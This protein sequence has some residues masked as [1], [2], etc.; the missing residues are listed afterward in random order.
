MFKESQNNGNCRRVVGWPCYTWLSVRAGSRWVKP[1]DCT[2]YSPKARALRHPREIQRPASL[3]IALR[4][5][6][7]AKPFSSRR[8]IVR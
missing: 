4:S 7:R 1:N 5:L 2:T 3:A 8:E 6:L